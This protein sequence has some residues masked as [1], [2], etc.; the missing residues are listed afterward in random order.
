[1]Y[2]CMD[3]DGIGWSCSTI[4]CTSRLTAQCPQLSNVH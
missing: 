2:G 3:V 1:M 4:V